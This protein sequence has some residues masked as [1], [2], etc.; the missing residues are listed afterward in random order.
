MHPHG[1]KHKEN[2][3]K[4]QTL[5]LKPT[6]PCSAPSLKTLV[7]C[8]HPGHRRRRGHSRQGSSSSLGRA[9]G[10]H[11]R[12]LHL[13]SARVSALPTLDPCGATSPLASRSS[14]PPNSRGEGG[15]GR[16]APSPPPTTTGA[17]RLG[18]ER[19]E[20]VGRGGGGGGGRERS[21]G[22]RENG[23]VSVGIGGGEIFTCGSLKR[24][25]YENMLISHV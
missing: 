1:K 4:I 10:A 22:E 11:A 20:K 24:P 14:L 12:A 21:G 17:Y 8:L 3:K 18:E 5:A 13:L 25:A 19:G 7:R 9:T 23:G 2:Q 16:R 15:G 6:T